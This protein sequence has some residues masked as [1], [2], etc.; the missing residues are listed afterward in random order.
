MAD[1]DLMNKWKS[2]AGDLVLA[3]NFRKMRRKMGLVLSSW[4]FRIDLLII[5]LASGIEWVYFR[6]SSINEPQ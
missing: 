3:W 6:Y 2:P 5:C 4:H 1:L